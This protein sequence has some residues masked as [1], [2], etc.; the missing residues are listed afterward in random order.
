MRV[1][2]PNTVADDRHLIEDIILPGLGDFTL[3]GMIREDVRLWLVLLYADRRR[4]NATG[5]AL[6]RTIL[7]ATVH[8][9]VRDSRGRATGCQPRPDPCP[10]VSNRLRTIE[11]AT[12]PS[13]LS[14]EFTR[15][16]RLMRLDRHSS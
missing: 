11:P 16:S 2:R 12:L 15:W 8:D 3:Q 7:S 6:R 1:L 4:T 14:V 10:G 13:S 5:Y 9:P